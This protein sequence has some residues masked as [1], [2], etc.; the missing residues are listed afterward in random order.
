MSWAAFVTQFAS[1][2]NGRTCPRMHPCWGQSAF[3]RWR[4]SAGRRTV[5]I[6]GPGLALHGLAFV[7][8]RLHLD[9]RPT[10]LC[11]CPISGCGEWGQHPTLRG[12]L[13]LHMACMPST[14]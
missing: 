1:P 12:V 14:A 5:R 4:G 2:G 13:T 6:R 9:C 10:Q 3:R 11:G 7:T 8:W